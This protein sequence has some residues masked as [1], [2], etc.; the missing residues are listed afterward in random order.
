ML[1]DLSGNDTY[2]STYGVSGGLG[3]DYGFGMLADLDGDDQYFGGTLSL[4]AA[5][6]SSLGILIDPEGADSFRFLNKS[7]GYGTTS[8]SIG[9]LLRE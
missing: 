9:V 7:L 8:T 1:I 6:A 2:S 4:G 5:T 3:H